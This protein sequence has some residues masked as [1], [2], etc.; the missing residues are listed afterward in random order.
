M[1][2]KRTAI[3][4]GV[5]GTTLVLL[6]LVVPLWSQWSEINCR[7]QDINIKTGRARYSRYLWF[8]KVSE[9]AKDTPLS[10][11]LR[12]RTVDVAR[13]DPW[14]RV[15]TFGPWVVYSP[16]YRFH[17]AL[18]QA[19]Q[20]GMAFELSQPSEQERQDVATH[21]LTLWQTHGSYFRADDYVLDLVNEAIDR[22]DKVQPDEPRQP[23]PLDPS[24]GSR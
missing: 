17:G 20:V 6:P 13:I 19:E 5:L 9:A 21:V 12:G 15:N 7:H 3:I 1:K 8:V 2:I 4:L 16:H 18:S 14:H 23:N 24:E 11:A 10:L 22:L